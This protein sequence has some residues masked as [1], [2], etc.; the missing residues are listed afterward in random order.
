[1]TSVLQPRATGFEPVDIVHLGQPD[2]AIGDQVGAADIE[3]VAA[4]A[5]Q[6]LEL[7]ARPVLSEIQPETAGLQPVEERPVDLARSR[8]QADMRAADQREGRT[9]H[10]QV[11][12]LEARPLLVERVG[13]LCARLDICDQRRAALDDR[14]RCAA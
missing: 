2:L 10:D 9:G 1:M 6:V 3:V 11:A 14:D 7:P 12:F 5:C 8:G 4:A 13:E